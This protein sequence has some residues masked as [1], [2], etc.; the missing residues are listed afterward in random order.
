MPTLRD[1]LVTGQGFDGTDEYDPLGDDHADLP[2]NAPQ[3][4]VLPADSADPSRPKPTSTYRIGPRN[5]NRFS[6]RLATP[7]R[8]ALRLL[9]YPA[10]R[11]QVNGKA[12]PTG[13]YGRLQ[14]DGDSG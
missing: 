12:G 14:S 2:L 10:W 3:A 11:V 7:V 13:A 5:R 4:K 1:A 8:V 9:N 6:S